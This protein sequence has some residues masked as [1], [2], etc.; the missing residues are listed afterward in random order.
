MPY[1]HLISNWGERVVVGDVIDVHS[2]GDQYSGEVVEVKA[3]GFEFNAFDHC[4]LIRAEF[5]EDISVPTQN[6]VGGR[7]QFF[8]F[9]FAFVSD[10]AALVAA[11]LFVGPADDR[12]FAD[13]AFGGCCHVVIRK[14]SG[15]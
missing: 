4:F 7:D 11:I 9:F 5:P 13:G 6:L 8:G 3:E 12:R 2:L 10:R 15:R 14:K 1:Q